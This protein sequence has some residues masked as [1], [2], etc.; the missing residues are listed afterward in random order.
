MARVGAALDAPVASTPPEHDAPR[1]SRV[2]FVFQNVKLF[3]ESVL[4]N[5]RAARPDATRDQVLAALEPWTEVRLSRPIRP[6]GG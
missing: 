3:K 2:A 4:E 1:G 6:F 5:V